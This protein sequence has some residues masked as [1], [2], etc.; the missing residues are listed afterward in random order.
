M[1]SL[2]RFSLDV[3]LRLC[4]T[5]VGSHMQHARQRS[6]V[7]VVVAALLHAAR[8]FE[9]AGGR[10]LFLHD[11]AEKGSSGKNAVV[12]KQNTSTST[13]TFVGDQALDLAQVSERPPKRQA[14][15]MARTKGKNA[16]RKAAANADA[17]Q[18][19]LANKASDSK[20]K[21]QKVA[22]TH[23]S[24]KAP[25]SDSK[26]LA[27]ATLKELL[28]G[29]DLDTFFTQYFEKKPLHVRNN[30]KHKVRPCTHQTSTSGQVNELVRT[31]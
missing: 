15:S 23:A 28:G 1:R 10:V 30:G 31:T 27:A 2:L 26:S 4:I 8:R 11:R 18:P 20:K 13:S 5:Y 12:H 29:M 17:Q 9:R 22:A 24:A 16:K 3:A 19:S 21:K 6:A 25:E 7:A 14:T